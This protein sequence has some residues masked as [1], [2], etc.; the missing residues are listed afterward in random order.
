MLMTAFEFIEGD[1]R[2]IE[3]RAGRHAKELIM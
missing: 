2:N 1:I 3:T